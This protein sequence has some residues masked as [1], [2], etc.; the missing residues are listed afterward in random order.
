MIGLGSGE[1]VDDTF[2]HLKS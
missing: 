2:S 1:N